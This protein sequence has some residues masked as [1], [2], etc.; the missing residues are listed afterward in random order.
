M[1]SGSQKKNDECQM[2]NLKRQ[3][4]LN[5]SLSLFVILVA[6]LTPAT[7]TAKTV[8][9]HLIHGDDRTGDGTYSRPYKS[10]RTALTHV[11]GGDTIIAKNGDYRA[12]GAQAR[13]GGL[14]LVLTMAD[15]LDHNDP[16]QPVIPPARPDT[17]GIYRYDPEH[18]LVIRAETKQGVIIDHI[19]FHMARAIVVDGFEIIPNP[20]YTDDAGH[21][22][23]RRRN[24]IH[25]D[26][27]YEPED[28][29]NRV[30][31]NDPPGGYTAVW[32]DRKL[33]TSY[34]TVRNCKIH[35]PCPPQGCTPAY[36]PL[37]DDDRL[38]LIKFNQ[39]HHITIEDCELF[40]GKNFQ[41]KPAIDLPCCDD[42]IVRRNLIRNS[43][44]G[45]VSK[46]GGK[47]VLIEANVFLDN[48][49]AAFSG[50]STD[51]NLFIDGR[52]GDPCSFA[53]FESYDMTAR[54]NLVLSTRPGERPVEPIAIWS[55][56]NALIEHNTFIGI[57][58]RGVLLVRPGNEV[59]SPGKDCGGSIRL[60]RTENLT[61][62]NNVFILS[63]VVDETMLYQVAGQGV[64][65]NGFV[66]SSNTFFNGG[67]EV[68]GGGLSDPNL[69]AGFSK[70][71]PLL[72]GG[73][74][75]DYVSWMNVAKLK[76]NSPSRGRGI[77]M[78]S[79]P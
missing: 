33:W 51:P 65:V 71:D 13:W 63:G 49:G 34:I 9:V 2:S 29:Y 19:R 50:G 8:Y 74:G 36:D 75:T 3:I 62:K 6:L 41:R 70:A 14:D 72:T 42:V 55:A 38:Y 4:I 25:G 28:S 18:P 15:Q 56:Q 61:L 5:A 10:W 35:Y 52:Y 77:Q 68:P 53:K 30:Q 43:H 20:Y 27:V 45:V 59:D 37:Q 79:V 67:R 39:S 60:V 7:T 12:A 31:T 46:G 24:G 44:R 22:L 69:E 47:R 1:E 64:N 76:I 58:E 21:K 17:V 11:G 32:Y 26:S 66:H 48:S 16:R 73:E 57:G 23:N 54:N 40:D 78:R